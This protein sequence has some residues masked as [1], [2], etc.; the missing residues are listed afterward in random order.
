MKFSSGHMTQASGSVG[1]LTYS[2]NRYGMYCRAKATPVNPNTPLQNAQR[3]RL[4]TLA[5]QWRDTLTPVQRVAWD[6]YALNT[7][8]TDKL[9]RSQTIT[10]LNWFIACNSLRLQ[11]GQVVLATAPTLFGLADLTPVVPTFDGSADTVSVAYTN[12]DEWAGEVGGFL[13]CFASAGKGVATNFFKGPY[14]Y[15]GKETGTV[16]PPTSPKVLSLIDLVAEGQKAFFRAIA[17]RADG[18]ISTPFLVGTTV[19][20]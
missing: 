17:I 18:R 14:K 1:G 3:Q 9:G 16:V 6:L 19:V 13:L 15:V 8:V 11:A 4:S 20:A 5:V 10:G 12:T 2:R 7:P